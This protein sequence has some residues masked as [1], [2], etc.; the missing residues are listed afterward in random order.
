MI[1]REAEWHA[2]EKRVSDGNWGKDSGS[3]REWKFQERTHC[4]HGKFTSTGL[5]HEPGRLQEGAA[6]FCIP[7]FTIF[8]QINL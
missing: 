2:G 3:Y 7:S 8:L 5:W 6:I 4:D 1:S